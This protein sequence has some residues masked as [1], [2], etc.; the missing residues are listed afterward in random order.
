MWLVGCSLLMVGLASPKKKKK[1]CKKVLHESLWSG[2]CAVIQCISA[3][4]RGTRWVHM[5]PEGYIN[6]RTQA[7]LTPA[8]LFISLKVHVCVCVCACVCTLWIFHLCGEEVNLIPEAFFNHT[9][10]TMNIHTSQTTGR[11]GGKDIK[12]SKD[13]FWVS[14][15]EVR[16]QTSSSQQ[17][18][19]HKHQEMQE[20]PLTETFNAKTCIPQVYSPKNLLSIMLKQSS[21]SR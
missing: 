19:T 11:D 7:S 14:A 12:G 5:S 15:D 16:E 18:T 17:K 13:T 3:T 6:K 21:W 4:P 20:L 2:L 8:S 10:S 1:P 9:Y